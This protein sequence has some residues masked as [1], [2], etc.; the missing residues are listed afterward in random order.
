MIEVK[1]LS[2]IY[3]EN[4]NKTVALESVSFS[5]ENGEFIAI[6]GASRKWKINTSSYARWSR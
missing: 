5:I 1:N 2:K 4:D 3:G 6:I